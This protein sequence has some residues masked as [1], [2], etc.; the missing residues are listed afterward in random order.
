MVGGVVVVQ[1]VL[2]QLPVTEVAEGSSSVEVDCGSILREMTDRD[3]DEDLNRSF[4]LKR[5]K[6]INSVYTHTLGVYPS[7]LLWPMLLRKYET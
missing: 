1:D 2:G 7:A 4:L 3:R 6:H 5:Q